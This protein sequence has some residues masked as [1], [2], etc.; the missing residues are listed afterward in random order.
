MKRFRLPVLALFGLLLTG[1]FACT[2]MDESKPS[3]TLDGSAWTLASLPG[4]PPPGS[5]VPT[6]AFDA[7]RASGSDGCN[8]YFAMYTPKPAGQLQFGQRGGTQMACP[9][10][11][12]QRAD[13]F[14]AALAATRAYR[15]EGGQLQ[16]LDAGG[17]VL[18]TFDPQESTLAGTGWRVTGY[19]NGKQAVVSVISGST[20][21]VSFG[22]DGKLSGSGG[23]NNFTGSYKAEGKTIGIGP[24]AATRK[25][26][27]QPEGVMTQE[28]A[29]LRALESAASARREGDRLELRTASGALAATLQAAAAPAKP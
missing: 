25:A 16:L 20:L 18:A 22:A 23:C 3:P 7:A 10:D 26:C 14:N 29:F 13:A 27:A 11:Q 6:L 19:N 5:A 15:V 28:A 2:S 17:T 1:L 8:R 24:L 21:G 4:G 12:S 9:P